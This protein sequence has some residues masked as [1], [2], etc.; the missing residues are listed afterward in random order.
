MISFYATSIES[1]QFP[2]TLTTLDLGVSDIGNEGVQSLTEALK[3]NRVR[4]HLFSPLAEHQ[5]CIRFIVVDANF[6]RTVEEQSR[7]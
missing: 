6:T 3:V 5:R 7:N 4:M 2:Q 1:F